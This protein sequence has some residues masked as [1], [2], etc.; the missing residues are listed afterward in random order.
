MDGRRALT[1]GAARATI[2]PAMATTRRKGA[3]AG[4]GGAATRR[5]DGPLANGNAEP[6]VVQQK[7]AEFLDAL[8]D[9]LGNIGAAA[10]HVGI[11]RQTHYD[12]LRTDPDYAARYAAAREDVIDR[13]EQEADRRA[14]IGLDKPIFHKGVQVGTFREPSDTLLIFRLKALR[15]GVYRERTETFTLGAEDLR[16][17]SDEQLEAIA[18]GEDPVAVIARG[19]RKG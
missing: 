16:G 9:R 3:A 13:M 6:D 5:G 7:K 2:G 18:A 1:P 17:L 14:L 4:D 8:A 12:W 10:K 11:G 19:P 15:P